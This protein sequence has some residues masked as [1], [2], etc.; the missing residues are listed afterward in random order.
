MFDVVSVRLDLGF[1]AVVVEDAEADV[2]DVVATV[3]VV[4]VITEVYLT[5]SPT[6]L[7]NLAS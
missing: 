5:F 1:V 7:S 6:E 3:V 4:D 2:D